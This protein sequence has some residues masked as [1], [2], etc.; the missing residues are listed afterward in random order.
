MG[1]S[2]A[3]QGVKRLKFWYHFRADRVL[4]ATF[5]FGIVKVSIGNF[6]KVKSRE[7]IKRLIPTHSSISLAGFGR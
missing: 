3:I 1:F 5:F 4:M 7:G 6:N 2:V